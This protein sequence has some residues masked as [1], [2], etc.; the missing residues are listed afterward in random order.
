MSQPFRRGVTIVRWFES[1]SP[2]SIRMKPGVGLPITK[3][4]TAKL[5]AAY[6]PRAI[7]EPIV[8]RELLEQGLRSNK[9][10]E[11]V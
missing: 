7:T 1:S 8:R 5:L 6:Q 9:A 2:L 4:A 3:S 11:S 10:V